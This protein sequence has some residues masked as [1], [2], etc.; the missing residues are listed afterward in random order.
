MMTSIKVYLQLLVS[1]DKHVFLACIIQV[2]VTQPKVSQHFDSIYF[3]IYIADDLFDF[4]FYCAIFKLKVYI[5][6]HIKYI[7]NVLL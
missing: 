5:E 7:D 3:Y 1:R 6:Y 4:V 2:A